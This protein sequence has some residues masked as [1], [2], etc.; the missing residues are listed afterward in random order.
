MEKLIE[1]IIKIRPQYKYL[2]LNKLFYQ[3]D[4]DE[5]FA[6]FLYPGKEPFVGEGAKACFD[7]IQKITTDI[8]GVKTTADY[9]KIAASEE[10]V[11]PFAL[12]LVKSELNDTTATQKDIKYNSQSDINELEIAINPL[13]Y[14]YGVSKSLDKII[15][16]Q[17]SDRFCADFSVILTKKQDTEDIDAI[18]NVPAQTEYVKTDIKRIIV[19][20]NVSHLL[21]NPIEEPAVYIKDLKLYLM[22]EAVVCGTISNFKKDYYASSKSK[23]EALG[24]EPKKDKIYYKFDL[25]DMTSTVSC[26]YFCSSSN[27]S[28]MDKLADGSQIILRGTVKEDKRNTY[29]VNV[30]SISYAEIPSDLKEVVFKK[31]APS[32]YS[33]VF[34]SEVKILSQV[35]LFGED[36]PPKSLMDK[37]YVVIDVETTGLGDNDKITEIGAIK[38]EGGRITQKFT[39]LVNPKVKIDFDNTA[40]TGITNEM[41]KNSP[42]YEEVVGDF[43]KF[44]DG[45]ILVGH[46]IEFDLGR[47][48][49]YAEVTH[50]YF[51]HPH[52]DTL[53]MGRKYVRGL[54]NYKLK[55]LAE[56]FKIEN[57]Q[58]HRALHDAMTTAKIFIELS[59][60]A[61]Q[62]AQKS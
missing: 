60:L 9:I 54:S 14:D 5:C 18:L 48:N 20:Q 56:Y 53:E 44:C 55:T 37:V 19:P 50:Y 8:L 2:R 45:A 49:L 57:E 16:S 40:I 59:R 6:Q 1:E 13:F 7:D 22:Q 47:I 62:N 23:A 51:E 25:T 61:E 46:N 12:S 29:L 33:V 28:K 42:T 35:S 11:T 36:V 3:P 34:P 31:S 52:I 41:V 58:A 39:T 32:C 10:F 15:A 27:E 43:Y 21:G 24:G 4:V 26:I 30:R 38:I 17:L